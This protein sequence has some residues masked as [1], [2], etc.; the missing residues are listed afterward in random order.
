MPTGSALQFFCK[1]WTQGTGGPTWWREGDSL[2]RGLENTQILEIHTSSPLKVKIAQ[3]CPTLCDLMDYI[4]HG[5]LQ[6]RIL[7]WVAF[8][9]S[10]GSFQ[11]RVFCIAGRFFT[12]WAI[13][14][15]L[16][17]PPRN[18]ASSSISHFQDSYPLS[19][20]GL[21][22]RWQGGSP[23]PSL[24]IPFPQETKGPGFKTCI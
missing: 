21:P 16:T 2:T 3:S 22:A 24:G 18:P 20:D 15:A 23:R 9:F 14:E 10:R 4:V 7:E 17:E 11:L 6:A 5:I 1:A 19:Q 12:N 8:H 13:R